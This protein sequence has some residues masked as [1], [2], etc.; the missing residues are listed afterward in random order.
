MKKKE[1]VD[2]NPLG[3]RESI[4]IG[5]IGLGQIGQE[6][7]RSYQQIPGANV[8][9][10]CGRSEERTKRM[11][12][13][14]GISEYTTD[15]RRLLDREDIDAVDVCLHNNLHRHATVAALEA[16]KDVYCEKPMAGTYHDA[17]AMVR[18]AKQNKKKLSI[19][20]STLFHPETKAAKQVISDGKLGRV[21]YASATG[22]RR[23][24]RPFVDGYGTATFVQKRWSGGGALQDMGVYHLTQIL[25][26]LGNPQPE[27]ITGRL[28]Q[29]MPMD[30]SRR[31]SSGYDVEELGVGFGFLTGGIVLN[32]FEAW[33]ANLDRSRGS[34]ILG[35]EGGVQFDPFA[36]FSTMGDLDLSSSADLDSF[37]YR[38]QTVRGHGDAY[39]SPQHHWI[40]ALLGKAELLPT[41]ELALTSILITE[42]IALS[43]ELGR[44]VS[45]HEVKERSESTSMELEFS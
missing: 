42:G 20:L 9:A 27:R 38:L 43:S 28:I 37:A 2:G 10:I 40:S 26:V 33:A 41:A 32:V 36:Y 12:E 13:N 17:E 22:Y 18:A 23:R 14:F 3:S 19:Q 45:A 15:Y 6:H 25:Y 35:S 7:I 39:S 24:G 4:N 29:E 21:Y 5:I 8:V 31:E 16:G 34:F 11:A 1:T 44:E 30:P